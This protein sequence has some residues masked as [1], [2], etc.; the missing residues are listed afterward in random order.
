[1]PAALTRRIVEKNQGLY[2]ALAI[3]LLAAI[4]INFATGVN[5]F[6][7]SNLLNVTRSFCML[8]IAAIGQSVVIISGGGGLDLSVGETISTANVIAATFMKGNNALFL[9]VT[10]LTLLF[11][12]LVGLTNGLLVTKRNVPPFIATLGIAILLRGLRLMWTEGLPQGKIPPVLVEVGVGTTLGVPNMFFVFLFV[13]V[14]IS[15]L[16]NRIG[17]GRRLYAV[18]NNPAV[19]HLCGIRSER[20]VLGAYIICGICAAMVGIL[21][22]G[23]MGMSDQKI[24]EGYALDSIAAAVLGGTAIT[25]GTGGVSG[26]IIGVIIMLLVTNLALLAQIPIQSQMLMKGILIIAALAF[27]ARRSRT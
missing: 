21:M 26:T 9:P 18:G 23:Y 25:G 13:A 11:G 16:L 24:G 17:Y 3:L 7:I 15:M 5:F 6:G 8:G 4:V 19:A 27:N 12:A 14:L 22:G 1:M 10:F 2:A 20:V